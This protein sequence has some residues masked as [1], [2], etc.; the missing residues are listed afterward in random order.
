MFSEPNKASVTVLAV[1]LLG[2]TL[3]QFSQ[4]MQDRSALHK[5]ADQLDTAVK[6]ADKTLA[7]SQKT[8]DQLNAIAIGTQRLS[9]AGNANAKEIVQQLTKLGI[10]INPNYKEDA[11]KAA[12]AAA[13][14]GT[15]APG[16]TPSSTAP[17]AT[18]TA[19]APSAP[20]APGK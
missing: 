1:A 2:F 6:E 15:A 17:S 18:P 3:F 11:A 16:A 8:L 12:A 5:F 20:A 13:A 4:I 10:R 19:P 9:D 7:E 14:T